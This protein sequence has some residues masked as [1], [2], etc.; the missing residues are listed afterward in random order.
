M[1]LKGLGRSMQ[2][3]VYLKDGMIHSQG[4]RFEKIK[5]KK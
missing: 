3:T 1:K 4:L 5:G 2:E